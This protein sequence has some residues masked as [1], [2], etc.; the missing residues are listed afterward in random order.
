MLN[1]VKI[2]G[3]ELNRRKILFTLL[4][5]IFLFK[6]LFYAV[7]LIPPFIWVTPDDMGHLSYIQYI[8]SQK[9]LPV[10][11]ET[12]IEATTEKVYQLFA[13]NM[14]EEALQ[15]EI[16]QETFDYLSGIN[17]IAQ[18][19]PLYYLLMTPVYAFTKLL[20]NN[21][22]IIVI[23]LRIATLLLGIATIYTIH[24]LLSVLN[25]NDIVYT[26]VL[27]AFVF[28]APIQ[29][30]FSIISNDSLLIFLCT[31]AL[32]FVIEYIFTNK[33]K[34]YFYFVIACAFIMLTKYNGVLVLLGPIT[35]IFY[36]ILKHNG[37]K[38]SLFLG[39]QGALLGAAII[40]PYFINNY[41]IHE[42]FMP[43][44][45]DDS[46]LYGY[47][48]NQ[49]FT[50]TGYFDTIYKNIIGLLGGHLLSFILTSFIVKWISVFLLLFAAFTYWKNTKKD[51]IVFGVV[52]ALVI[53]CLHVFFKIGWGASAAVGSFVLIIIKVITN[54]LQDPSKRENII[55]VFFAISVV[56]MC[57]IYFRQHFVIYLNRGELG[58]MHG[59]YYY[60]A[61]F[62]ILYMVYSRF[63]SFKGKIFS[64]MPVALLVI[65]SFCEWDFIMQC[66]K[67][68]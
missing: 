54:Y 28:C 51:F 38:R 56:I 58:A 47:T 40:A 32:F 20:T 16:G 27:I 62:P 36:F 46:K 24:R 33:N 49:F 9:A 44:Y 64:F 23:V 57:F 34:Y 17:H 66:I 43:I 37:L 19:P 68:W 41:L 4:V 1:R 15:V 35:L 7:Y 3:I 6:G 67:L 60:I 45:D 18:H 52:A 48:F 30:F 26:C 50:L 5:L 63:D 10:L 31:L 61:I 39:L 21:F 42:T 29:Y 12:N 22:S 8:A 65:M 2:G 53:S 55:E 11:Y 59:R 14:S 25:V 13:S